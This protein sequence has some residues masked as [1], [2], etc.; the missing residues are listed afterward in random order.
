VSSRDHAEIDILKIMHRGD[1]SWKD[2]EEW[3]EGKLTAG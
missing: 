3:R 2:W 1:G